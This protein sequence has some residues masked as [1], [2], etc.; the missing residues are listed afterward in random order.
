[1]K[2]KEILST[3]DDSVDIKQ[4][5]VIGALSLPFMPEAMPSKP[6]IT[7]HFHMSFSLGA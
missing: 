7:E 5:T 1:M 6:G 2:F 4:S 3:I